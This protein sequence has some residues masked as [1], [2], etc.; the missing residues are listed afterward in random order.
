[1]DIV[2]RELAFLSIHGFLHL[3]GYDHMEKAER[4]KM[5]KKQEL[6]LDGYGIRDKQRRG[7]KR[8]VNSFKYS[9]EGLKY[10]Y[11]YE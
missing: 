4:R 3:L 11:K 10:A 5:F 2:F 8:F 7:F 6:I 1:M 9:Y